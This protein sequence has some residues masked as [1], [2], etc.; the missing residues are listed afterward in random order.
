[1]LCLKVYIPYFNPTLHA[2]KMWAVVQHFFYKVHAASVE[3]FHRR[4]LLGEGRISKVEARQKETRLRGNAN[5]DF[6]EKS[7]WM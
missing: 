3:I 5:K 7:F 6:H 4:M 2:P 1:M